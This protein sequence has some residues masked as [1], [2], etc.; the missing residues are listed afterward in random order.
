M[1]LFRCMEGWELK[2]YMEGKELLGQSNTSLVKG[3]VCFFPDNPGVY[4]GKEGKQISTTS[5]DEAKYF[6]QSNSYGKR[7]FMAVFEINERVLQENG[8]KSIQPYRAEGLGTTVFLEELHFDSYSNKDFKIRELY[9]LNSN[10]IN[11]TMYQ[12]DISDN[13]DRRIIE[14]IT[15]KEKIWDDKENGVVFGSS[16]NKGFI[17]ETD[18]KYFF[19]IGNGLC[20]IGNESF[21]GKTS[22]AIPP[23][24]QMLEF[25]MK[26]KNETFDGSS[27]NGVVI[28]LVPDITPEKFSFA[29]NKR[30]L[31]ITTDFY[32]IVLEKEPPNEINNYFHIG[33]SDSPIIYPATSEISIVI[34]KDTQELYIKMPNNSWKHDD[35]YIDTITMLSEIN[36]TPEH[37]L[38]IIKNDETKIEEK[39]SEFIESLT[40]SLQEYEEN[41]SSKKDENEEDM[42]L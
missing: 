7:D 19:S 28:E 21:F 42:S 26:Y 33:M 27:Y 20:S 1:R 32:R 34:D 22:S 9:K 24:T 36:A 30:M 31:E 16:N 14:A 25:M 12:L 2:K 10:E 15:E 8:E 40:P 5:N 13:T 18:G 29:E 3:K 38:I 23:S 35:N 17:R 11:S 37:N 39:A 41:F 6:L 4:D